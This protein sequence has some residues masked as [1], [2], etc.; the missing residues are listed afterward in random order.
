MRYSL[1]KGYIPLPKSVN[2]TRI[3]SNVNI[4]DLELTQDEMDHLD[5]LDEEL[6]TD[7]DPTKCP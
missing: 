2:K 1:Q 4:F 5:S 3:E 7:W 6:V